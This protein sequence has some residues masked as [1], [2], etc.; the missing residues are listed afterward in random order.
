M[1]IMAYGELDGLVIRLLNKTTQ[2]RGFYSVEKVQDAIQEALTFIA[3]EAFLT[4]QGWTSKLED[5]DTEAG[6]VTYPVRPHW[7]MIKKVFYL[8]GTTYEELKYSDNPRS[9][10][11]ASS[12][13]TQWPCTYRIV[14]NK[15]YFDSPLAEGG[16]D[17]LRV[18]F[19]G[20]PKVPQNDIDIIDF[21]INPLWVEFIK[22]HTAR[23]LYSDFEKGSWNKE[24]LYQDWLFKLRAM[25]AKRNLQSGT[26]QDAFP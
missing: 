6:Q 10:P 3:S 21:H 1:S 23:V 4:G 5:V 8:V 26:V 2:N 25:L 24:P 13:E 20:F 7:A 9:M 18:E 22:Y 12:G 15:I 17:Y 16:T 19:V 14:D 11:A